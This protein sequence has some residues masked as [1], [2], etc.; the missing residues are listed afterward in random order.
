[1]GP[2][3]GRPAPPDAAPAHLPRA[4]RHLEYT[5]AM[6]RMATL[7][8]VLVIGALAAA[9]LA[10][11]AGPPALREPAALSRLT[12]E[13]RQQFIVAV[14]RY[15]AADWAGAATTFAALATAPT[16]IP[17]Y[18]LYL[19][20]DSLARLDDA[21]AALA[22]AEQ[23]ASLTGDGPLAAAALL[24][25]GQQAMRAGKA[26]EAA[27]LLRRFTERH[28]AHP[29]TTRAR[30]MLGQALDAAGQ[31]PEAVAAYRRVWL[32]APA[33]PFADLA[34][35]A[36]RALAGRG[37]AVVPPEAPDRVE[38]AER[39]LGA[40]RAGA[41]RA[42]AD[43]LLGDKL[44]A[45]LT[46]RALRV[47][48]EAARRE[49]KL[50]VAA[51]AIDRALAV[52]RGPAR[53]PW[54]L[55]RARLQQRQNR[56]G[57]LALLDRLVQEHPGAPEAPEA[58]LLAARLLEDA[59][60]GAEAE[61]AYRRVA[62]DYRD[63]GAAGDAL[64]RLGW[65]AWEQGAHARAAERWGT[66]LEVPGGRGYRDPASYW[67]GRVLEVRGE[68][69]IAQRRYETLVRE[70]PRT[71]YGVLASARLADRP[72]SPAPPRVG[73]E[74]LRLAVTLPADPLES[75]RGEAG[76]A[77]IEALRA[78]GLL[79]FVEPEVEALGR[80][81]ADPVRLYGVAAFHVEDARYHAA[82]RILR[83]AFF[84]QARADDAALPPR[85]WQM[86]YPLDW[87]ELLDASAARAA[88]D[89]MLV[90]A[91]V[92]EESAFS[93]TARSRAGARGLMQLMPATARP[94]ARQRG[95]DFRGGAV[96]EEPAANLDMGASYL[97]GLLRQFGDPRLAVAAYNAG[98]GRVRSWVEARRPDDVEAWVELIP[99]S[100]TRA[101]VKRVMLSWD[102][103][104]RQYPARP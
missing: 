72:G 69:E 50:D 66:L 71:Y 30:F 29:E 92:R 100:E 23:A 5:R 102:E 84:Q 96:L 41:A 11:A 7:R 12:D 22:A 43:A 83:R 45:D 75:L 4:P 8:V 53:A 89:P 65:M 104:R 32:G 85:F 60:R 18:A 91:V 28:P 1:M 44:D 9:S 46:L 59:G 82:I 33:S 76:F 94:M 58:L 81:A 95:L 61:T 77:R 20:A 99:F 2:A 15:R 38:R 101:F 48:A 34:A 62:S 103:Y 25:A 74:T 54:L 90:A 97:G 87:R 86:L 36:E 49:G 13:L 27:G 17:E 10:A 80:G 24:L 88:L 26:A 52:A 64:W 67:L 55:A 31:L 51:R 70:A 39:L 3:R 57:A 98:P 42:E 37:V 19:R 35:A 21:E 40:G 6:R 47:S 16:P 93:P 79:E 78:V 14:Q 63:A 68:G 73:D 56:E